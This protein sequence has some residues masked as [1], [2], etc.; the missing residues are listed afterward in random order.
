MHI[1]QD[2]LVF[3]SITHQLKTKIYEF[4]KLTLINYYA[5]TF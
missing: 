4:Y 5:L 3:V 2:A 1:N